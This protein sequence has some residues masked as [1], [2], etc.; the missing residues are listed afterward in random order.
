MVDQVIAGS[1]YPDQP[2]PTFVAGDLLGVASNFHAG[3]LVSVHPKL[4]QYIR[5]RGRGFFERMRSGAAEG[6][7]DKD[8]NPVYIYVYI[9]IYIYVYIFIYIYIYIYIYRE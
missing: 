4:P 6:E 8:H 3:N 9:Y 7:G 5:G 1:L 2:S